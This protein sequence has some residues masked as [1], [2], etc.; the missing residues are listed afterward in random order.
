M[1]S[2]G[3][4]GGPLPTKGTFS[5]H[6]ACNLIGPNGARSLGHKA[7]L[8]ISEPYIY[9]EECSAKEEERNQ[10]IANITNGIKIG[11]KYF[12]FDNKIKKIILRLRGKAEGRIRIH[13]DAFDGVL[14]GEREISINNDQWLD[15]EVPIDRVS[16]KC[17]IFIDYSGEGFIE[18]DSFT[19]E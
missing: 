17:G 7:G 16:G 10:Y 18:F 4:S 5:S 11:F 9:E 13:I 1:T 19:F 3:L 12:L 2:C 8:Q 14:I 6:I 15:S